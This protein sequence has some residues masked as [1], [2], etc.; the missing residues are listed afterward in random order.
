MSKF[1]DWF[2]YNRFVKGDS[3]LWMY[4]NKEVYYVSH[5]KMITKKIRITVETRKNRLT[6]QCQKRLKSSN[7]P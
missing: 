5:P 7:F 4:C 3:V 2:Y 1:K 6:G